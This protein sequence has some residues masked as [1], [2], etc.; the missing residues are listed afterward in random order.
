MIHSF[1]EE[2]GNDET[3]K[4]D[5]PTYK[6]ECNNNVALL[7]R[8]DKTSVVIVICIV[9]RLMWGYNVNNLQALTL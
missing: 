1:K 4:F 8:S 3:F 9:S 6:I 5:N 7:E 2:L